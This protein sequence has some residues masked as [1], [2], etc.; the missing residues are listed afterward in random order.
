M[1]YLGW[2][3]SR[4]RQTPSDEFAESISLAPLTEETIQGHFPLS[5]SHYVRLLS[6]EK[7]Q[8]RSFYEAEALRGGWSVRRLRP[9]RRAAGEHL[10]EDRPEGVDVRRGPHG[11]GPA[12]G[13]LGGHVAG[14]PERYAGLG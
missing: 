14:G 2:G 4:I 9:E 6:V 13:L 12:G 1:F 5:W 3:P 11:V 10:V 7:P 8:A